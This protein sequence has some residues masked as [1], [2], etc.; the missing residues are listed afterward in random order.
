MT[1]MVIYLS[2]WLLPCR[3]G[4]T[5]DDWDPPASKVILCTCHAGSAVTRLSSGRG[6]CIRPEQSGP[7]GNLNLPPDDQSERRN[8]ILLPCKGMSIDSLIACLG[9]LYFLFANYTSGD[10]STPF[11]RTKMHVVI[12][13]PI[14]ARQI[15]SLEL[16]FSI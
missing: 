14:A 4:T 2:A 10:S 13:S 8:V 9:G 5:R 16:T 12:V 3:G 7:V 15:M 11:N 1:C 6:A